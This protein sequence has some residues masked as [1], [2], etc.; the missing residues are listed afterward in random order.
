MV[1]WEGAVEK[2]NKK[3]ENNFIFFFFFEFRALSWS[4]R[5]ATNEIT[6]EEEYKKSKC[7]VEWSD[8]K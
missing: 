2:E 5:N 7:G 1:A 6:K 3:K 8:Y 4:A